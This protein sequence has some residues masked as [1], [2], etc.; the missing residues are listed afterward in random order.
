MAQPPGNV[1][2]LNLTADPAGELRA[3]VCAVYRHGAGTHTLRQKRTIGG[4]SVRAHTKVPS[5]RNDAPGRAQV[6]RGMVGWRAV[7]FSASWK[8]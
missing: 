5:R 6:T 3:R 1:A 2:R 8:F 7:L 4:G